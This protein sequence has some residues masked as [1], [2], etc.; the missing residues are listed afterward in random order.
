MA[1]V[2]VI[3]AGFVG[4]S[5]AWWL[6]RD[7][8]EV[9]VFDPKGP[10]GGA[11]FGNAGTF[12]SYACIPINNPSVFRDLPRYLFASHSP[13]R[14]RLSYLPALAPWLMSFL[15]HSTTR[16]YEE[17]AAHLSRLLAQ[18]LDG[19]RDM[20]A[21]AGLERFVERRECLYLYSSE[22]AFRGNE[23]SLALRGR[24]G[25][26]YDMLDRAAIRDAEPELAPIFPRG[27]RFRDTFFLSDP[28][29]FLAA[30][31]TSL[32]AG[33]VS[34]MAGAVERIGREGGRT[35]VSVDGDAQRF[36]RVVVA[37]GAHSK[38]LAG[39]CGDAVPL[40]TERGHHVTFPGGEALVSR[41]VGW[42]ERGLYMTPMSGGLRVAGS[43]EL[44]GLR[45]PANRS[46][47][48]LLAFSARRALPALG[49][50]ADTWLGFRPTLPDGLPVL[51]PASG[52][53]DVIYAFGHQHIGL[54]LGGLTGRI[55][56][57]VVAGRAPPLDLA[58]FSPRRF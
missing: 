25:V 20:I 56:A 10:A 4:L 9:T 28:G 23:P 46:L 34:V 33:G 41:P 32:A 57:D 26:R 15:R 42:A 21:E 16:R 45:P 39:Q 35:F 2:A 38:P 48:D 13:F 53:P 54:T 1:E 37:T 44:A 43:V 50:A 17:A 55:V 31:A 30:L 12:A 5:S 40:D 7:G 14:L 47:I 18:A 19:Y 49:P 52:N 51:G 29:A 6:R 24:L 58:P 27:V 8:H 3:G 11:S 36:D 22:T